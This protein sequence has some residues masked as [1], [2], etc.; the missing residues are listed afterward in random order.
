MAFL[1]C[2]VTALAKVCQKIFLCSKF[3]LDSKASRVQGYKWMEY[4]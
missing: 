3:H 1:A 2:N 4:D